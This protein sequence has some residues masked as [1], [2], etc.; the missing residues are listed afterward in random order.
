MSGEGRSAASRTGTIRIAAGV[1]LVVL[2]AGAGTYWLWSRMQARAVEARGSAPPAPAG[3]ASSPGSVGCLG[4]IEPKDGLIQVSGTYLAGHPQRVRELKVREG[5]TVHAGQLLAILDGREDLETAVRLADARVDLARAQ[6]DQ[7]QAGASASEIAAQK[8]TVAQLQA[9]VENAHQEYDRYAALH[10]QTDVSTSDLDA[11][12]LAVQTAEE[13][14]KAAEARLQTIAQVRPTDLAVAQSQLKVAMAEAASARVDLKA[15]FVEAPADGRVVRI[16]TYP[17]EEAG[18]GPILDLGRIGSMYVEAEVYESDIARVHTGQ[19]AT[20]TS[21]L[22]PGKLTGVVE[23]IG[24][25]ISKAEVLPLDPVTYADAR[26][27]KVWIR[28]DD[29]ARVANLLRGKVNVVIQP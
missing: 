27:F 5:D 6:L 2:V 11:R 4:Y 17:G 3:A 29:G 13:Q 15:A 19:A 22:F 9:S 16:E 18:P 10:R 8:A 26:V 7:V 12:R 20:M 24:T 25:T 14:L 28:L 23:S 1:V 21:E